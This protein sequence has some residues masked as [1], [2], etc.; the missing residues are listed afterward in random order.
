MFDKKKFLN[1][2]ESYI[3]NDTFENNYK[4]FLAYFLSIYKKFDLEVIIEDYSLSRNSHYISFKKGNDNNSYYFIELTNQYIELRFPYYE[5]YLLLQDISLHQLYKDFL[6]SFFRGEYKVCI[7]LNHKR[8]STIK[9]ISWT[10]EKLNSFNISHKETI[11]IDC[12]EVKYTNGIN[13]LSD[14]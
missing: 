8:V 4:A 7:C 6:A 10:K 5:Q 1:E 14:N 13:F 12:V 9:E 2:I 11:S 3:F